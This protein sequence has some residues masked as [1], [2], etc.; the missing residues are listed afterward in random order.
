VLYS[1]Y[2]F[3]SRRIW[4][5]NKQAKSLNHY[6]PSLILPN[7]VITVFKFCSLIFHVNTIWH[8]PIWA[9]NLKSL[10]LMN[11]YENPSYEALLIIGMKLIKFSVEILTFTTK[12]LNLNALLLSM[13]LLENQTPIRFTYKVWSSWDVFSMD[14]LMTGNIPEPLFFI[15]HM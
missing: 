3:I 6:R 8:F 13:G 7:S 1:S 9:K 11:W 5:I 4:S 2:P 10:K 12:V 15:C 14:L